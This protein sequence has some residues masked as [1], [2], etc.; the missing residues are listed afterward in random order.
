MECK[1][2][3]LSNVSWHAERL[4]QHRLRNHFGYDPFYTFEKAEETSE[5]FLP[6]VPGHLIEEMFATAPGNEIESG[7]FDKPECS[8]RL[9]A[10]AFGY[11]LEGPKCLP[12][13]PGWGD[14][15]WPPKSVALEKTVRFPWGGGRHPVLDVFIV[16]RSVLIGIESKRFEPFRTA[17]T[18]SD[19]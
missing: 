8:A 13:L 19:A 3:R 4:S 9:A 15:C 1:R 6:G 2:H 14:E 12:P 17:P 7:N 18:F 16:T 10:N 11:F 5:R